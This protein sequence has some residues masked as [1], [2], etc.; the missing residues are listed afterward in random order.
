MKER[1]D[2]LTLHDLIELSCG[3]D[4]VLVEGDELVTEEERMLQAAKILMEY[5]SIASPAQSKLDLLDAEKVSKLRMKEKCARI[6][7]LL[8]EQGKHDMAR[9]VLRIFSVS[10]TAMRTD[11]QVLAQCQ[12][13]LGEVEYEAKRLEDMQPKGKERTPQEVRRTWYSEIASVMGVFKMTIDPER[14]N[15]AIYANLVAQAV[16]RSKALAKMPAMA[17]TMI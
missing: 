11:E 2:Q 1:L 5:K 13:L 8:C 10:E 9:E 7:I 12:A 3:D 15:A 6:C 4:T 17:R 14:T 16:E